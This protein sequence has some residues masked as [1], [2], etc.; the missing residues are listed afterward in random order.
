MLHMYLVPAGFVKL[1]SSYCI[2]LQVRYSRF[3][4]ENLNW[5]VIRDYF[6]IKNK[7]FRKKELIIKI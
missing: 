2:P 1:A 7:N 3:L 4:R 5:N 6:N